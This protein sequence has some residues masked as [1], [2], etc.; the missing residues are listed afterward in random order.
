M[1]AIRNDYKKPLIE[2]QIKM[3]ELK[4]YLTINSIFSAICGI[5]MLVLS[6]GLNSFFNTQNEYIFPII[7]LNLI[8]FSGFV[9]FVS[10][11]QL[12]NKILVNLISGLD[13]L[14]VLG[15]LIIIL[16]GLFD[17]SRNG[18]ILIGIVALWIAFLG[19]KQFKN[20]K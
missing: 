4:K 8:I 18:N 1:V 9:W 11:K 10:Q 12:A 16:F 14:W 20:N 17:L 5:I 19:Y 3:K 2:Y 7:G 6:S 15:S 13:A